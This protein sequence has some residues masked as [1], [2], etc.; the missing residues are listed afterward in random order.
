MQGAA[1]V[2]LCQCVSAPPEGPILQCRGEQDWLFVFVLAPKDPSLLVLGTVQMYNRDGLCHEE[3]RL[4]ACL[5]Y[6]LSQPM[7]G[8]LITTAV[9]TTV[10][11]AHTS[12]GGVH[13]HQE[14]FHQLKRGSGRG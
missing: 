12:I 9:I 2:S 13:A 10:A 3:R 1:N 8:L 5:H 11:G 6:N 14:H 7:L 4:R